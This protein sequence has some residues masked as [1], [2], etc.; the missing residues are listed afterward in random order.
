MIENWSKD[1]S[2]I[3]NRSKSAVMEFIHRR[4]KNTV[5]KVGESFQDYPIV[6]HYKYLGT[7]LDQ[8]FTVNTPLR[9]I[10]QKTAFILKRL[11][12]ILYH[13]S[14]DFRRNLWQ[15]FI[16]PLY[17]FM[18]PIYHYEQAKT[19]REKV[20][21]SLRM[22]FKRFTSLGRTVSSKLINELVG[23]SLQERGQLLAYLSEQKWLCRERGAYY[24]PFQD[25]SFQMP[26]PRPNICKNQPKTMIKYINM[27]NA[28]C[29][30]CT[31]T[32]AVN[33]NTIL[34]VSKC[35]ATHLE[36]VHSIHLES[37]ESITEAVMEMSEFNKYDTDPKHRITR[38]QIMEY[39]KQRIKMSLNKLKDFLRNKTDI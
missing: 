30:Y 18:L 1:N 32:I 17:E 37:I 8:K 25:R 6:E 2:L 24:N 10:N 15:T 27:Q 16:L 11:K 28:L 20:E 13:A 22:W 29:P 21:L 23:Y 5:L 4:K 3:I 7:W 9:H 35:S 34:T 12:P 39:A 14:L 31:K 38:K 33:N 26:D 19:A 36:Q